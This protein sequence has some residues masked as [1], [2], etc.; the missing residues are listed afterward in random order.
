MRTGIRIAMFPAKMLRHAEEQR[1]SGSLG[2]YDGCI[3]GALGQTDIRERAG[4]PSREERF[5]LSN[6]AI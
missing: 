6:I 3:V 2:W 4:A 5:S 1:Q